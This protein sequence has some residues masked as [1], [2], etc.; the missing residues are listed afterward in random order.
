MYER[1]G[2]EGEVKESYIVSGDRRGCCV[3]I[4]GGEGAAGAILI[5]R[6]IFLG[7]KAYVDVVLMLGASINLN[8]G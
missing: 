1:M 6:I 4:Y 3:G 2:K 8:C 5:A 7:K